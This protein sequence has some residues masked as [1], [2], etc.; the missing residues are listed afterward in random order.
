MELTFQS[1]QLRATLT[2]TIRYS[3]NGATVPPS[4]LFVGDSH[5]RGWRHVPD[6]STFTLRGSWSGN[7]TAGGQTTSELYHANSGIIMPRTAVARILR[8]KD[9]VYICMESRYYTVTIGS[10]G[11]PDAIL[12]Y[13]A[14]R[15]NDAYRRG[16]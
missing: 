1:P 11:M 3:F 5:V 7:G 13:V 8:P 16:L 9:N 2:L 12:K 4:P 10:S 6:D 15:A 14:Y